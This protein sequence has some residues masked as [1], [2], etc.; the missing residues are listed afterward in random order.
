[1][2]LGGFGSSDGK[3]F[4]LPASVDLADR[5]E[6]ALR[7]NSQKGPSTKRKPD[8]GS[9]V[10]VL[11]SRLPSRAR[12]HHAPYCAISRC[13]ITVARWDD[14]DH[15]MTRL[16]IV[17]TLSQRG[18]PKARPRGAGGRARRCQPHR[19]RAGDCSKRCPIRRYATTRRLCAKTCTSTGCWRNAPTTTAGGLHRRRHRNRPEV[20]RPNPAY[21][22]H[23]VAHLDD[24]HAAVA[25]RDSAKAVDACTTTYRTSPASTR[26]ICCE[27][28]VSRVAL[29][30]RRSGPRQACLRAPGLAPLMAEATPQLPRCGVARGGAGSPGSCGARRIR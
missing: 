30:Q 29:H 26:P 18:L 16:A 14:S 25:Q 20:H 12:P 8:P 11:I 7:S 2:R 24:V 5:P 13:P 6:V 10:V 22:E 21:S 9:G 27:R 19:R 4:R 3:G 23:L 1:M 28:R 17:I 15:G